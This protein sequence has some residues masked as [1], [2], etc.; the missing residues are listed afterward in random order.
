MKLC[1]LH[2]HSLASDGSCTPTEILDLAEERGL[3]AVALC[4]HNN[5]NG[6]V[7]FYDAGKERAVEAI[8]GV[9]ITVDYEG[10]ELHLLGLY[11][12]RVC[13]GRLALFLQ[14][15]DRD[16]ENSNRSLVASLNRAGYAID[17]DEIKRKNP[18]SLIN[19]VQIA[20]ELMEKGYVADRD[21]A[22]ATLLSEE[23]GH[24]KPGPR[25]SIWTALEALLEAEAVPVL[26][27]PLLQ[28][29]REELQEF[30]PKAKAKGLVGMECYYSTYDEEETRC[31]LE[32]AAEFGLVP[33]GGSDFHGDNKPHISLG[34][35]VGNLQV[36]YTC[37]Q[38]LKPTE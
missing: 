3:S 26:A 29:N 7:E 13:F 9:E 21:E 5:L 6:L 23:G 30:L 15:T 12:P 38:A 27:H 36:P 10:T 17:Y 37:A 24:Y 28:M 16:K 1:D 14:K 4:D 34:T 25:L 32:L 18:K 31:A 22:F 2:T 35:G 8:P 19:R 11:I 33:S 20:V